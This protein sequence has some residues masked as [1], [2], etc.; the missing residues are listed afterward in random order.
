M[1]VEHLGEGGKQSRDRPRQGEGVIELE[2]IPG[3][4]KTL[5]SSPSPSHPHNPSSPLSSTYPPTHP[6]TAQQSSYPSLSLLLNGSDSLK[7]GVSVIV[8]R[9][10]RFGMMISKLG[11]GDGV[12][13]ERIRIRRMLGSVKSKLVLVRDSAILMTRY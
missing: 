10:G 12:R 11:S 8:T 7:R 13:M 3:P 2:L 4:T 5:T 6:R 1:G 9:R